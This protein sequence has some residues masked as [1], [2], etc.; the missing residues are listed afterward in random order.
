LKYNDVLINFR[1]FFMLKIR[2]LIKI[3]EKLKILIRIDSIKFSATIGFFIPTL[4][5]DNFFEVSTF[6]LKFFLLA[7]KFQ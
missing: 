3:I 4:F 1:M 7:N 6:L 2:E 5:E